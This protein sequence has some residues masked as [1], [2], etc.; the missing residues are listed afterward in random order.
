MEHH[1]RESALFFRA[2][3]PD[4][5]RGRVSAIGMIGLLSSPPS[6]MCLSQES[7]HGASAP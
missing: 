4:E 3:F 5:K 1:S 7:S 2:K 6:F